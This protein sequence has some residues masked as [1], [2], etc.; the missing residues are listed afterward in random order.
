MTS[1][2]SCLFVCFHY[3][4][5]CRKNFSN[6][7]VF[8]NLHINYFIPYK[9]FS[10]QSRPAAARQLVLIRP[11]CRK[12]ILFFVAAPPSSLAILDGKLFTPGGERSAVRSNFAFLLT[13]HSET[14]GVNRKL[15]KADG[16]CFCSSDEKSQQNKTLR[17]Q[18]S[19]RLRGVDSGGPR[20]SL[21]RSRQGRRGMVAGVLSSQHQSGLSHLSP[22]LTQGP[23]RPLQIIL[24]RSSLF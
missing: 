7:Q 14:S 13:S 23:V 6:L 18:S 12:F 10:F 2:A 1:P 3:S 19:A 16:D 5:R 4:L 11:R 24:S 22:L 20:P 21:R 8:S 9:K 15:M 17:R